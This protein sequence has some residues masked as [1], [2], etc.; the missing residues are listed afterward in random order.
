VQR[1]LVAN[2]AIIDFLY[3]GWVVGGKSPNARVNWR[4]GETQ[5]ECVNLGLMRHLV[6]TTEEVG[7]NI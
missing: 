1:L 5:S 6:A 7:S 3:F 2:V 4:C